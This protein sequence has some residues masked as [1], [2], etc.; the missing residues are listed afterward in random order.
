MRCFAIHLVTAG[1]VTDMLA[2]AIG[3]PLTLRAIWA[4]AGDAFQPGLHWVVVIIVCVD[5][6]MRVTVLRCDG[7]RT[8]GGW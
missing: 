8:S 6:G 5:G 7:G 1:D 2:L 3:M 4:C